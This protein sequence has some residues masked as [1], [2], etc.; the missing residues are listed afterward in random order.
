MI[1]RARLGLVAFYD[2]RPGRMSQFL[3]SWN[4]HGVMYNTTSA[5]K[6]RY[7]TVCWLVLIVA[8]SK[9]ISIL[10]A[11]KNS[12]DHSKMISYVTVK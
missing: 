3:Q 8:L 4:L 2:I 12:N 6:Q 9:Q 7:T 11:Y 1:D 10:Q 5:L